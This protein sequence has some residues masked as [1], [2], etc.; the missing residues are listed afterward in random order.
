MALAE[1]VY[2]LTRT[3]PRAEIYGLTA[4]VSRSAG[5]AKGAR[6]WQR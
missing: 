1:D 6:R 2:A 4:Q 5:R 3:F